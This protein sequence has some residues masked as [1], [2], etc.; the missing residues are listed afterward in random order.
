MGPHQPSL[1]VNLSPPTVDQPDFL[2]SGANSLQRSHSHHGIISQPASSN[3]GYRTHHIVSNGVDPEHA[4]MPHANSPDALYAIQQMQRIKAA[5]A[6][7]IINN[8][9]VEAIR[10]QQEQKLYE[11][12]QRK[13]LFPNWRDPN[14]TNPNNPAYKVGPENAKMVKSMA[15]KNKIKKQKIEYGMDCD[16]RKGHV[17]IDKDSESE[18]ERKVKEL[19]LS[20]DAAEEA[21]HESAE[22]TEN[23]K[24]MV[25]LQ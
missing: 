25:I 23:E 11:K 1:R 3:G 5:T 14:E 9:V 12:E 15:K 8:R 17:F 10:Q 16:D 2:N 6:C 7:Q 22:L 20:L 4:Y 19:L 18:N 21:Q 13:K 24:L